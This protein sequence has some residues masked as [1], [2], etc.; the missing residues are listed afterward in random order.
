MKV[1]LATQGTTGDV[2]PLLALAAGLKNRGHDVL[3]CAPPDYKDLVASHGVSFH[4]VGSSL[5]DYAKTIPDPALHPVRAGIHLTGFLKRELVVQIRELSE[6]FRGCDMVLASSLMLGASTAAEALGIPYRFVAYC[7]QLIP[8]SEYPSLM[9]RNHSLPRWMNRLSWQFNEIGFGKALLGIWNVERRRLG[10]APRVN[11]TPQWLGKHVIVAS[12]PLLGEV[13]PDAP[14]SCTQ[15]GY[16]HLDRKEEVPADLAD[17]LEGS[18]AVYVGFGSMVN[19]DPAGIARLL[20]GA[21]RSVGCRLVLSR[22]WAGFHIQDGDCRLAGD[23]PHSQLFPRVAAVV[24]HGGSGTTATAARAGVPQVIVPH[25]TDQFYWATQ[26]FR[27]GLGPEGIWRVRLTQDRLA[28]ALHACLT[29]DSI[30]QRAIA[31][32]AGLAK[33]NPL[34]ATVEAVERSVS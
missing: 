3:F 34:P 11:I 4:S 19:E 17:F 1:G 16:L 22:G 32:A 10:L 12:D 7:P 29:Q 15:T 9:I 27:R 25:V 26:I 13:P 24:H 31:V 8:S 14:F 6:R 5:Q 21:A 33:T 20:L 23:V 30:R 28:A 2:Q 18:P